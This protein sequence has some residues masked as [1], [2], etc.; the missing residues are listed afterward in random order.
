MEPFLGEIRLFP[1]NFAPKGW[2]YCDGSRLAISANTALFSLLGTTYGGNGV[3]NFA[4][5]DLRGRVAVSQ[6]QGPGL[7]NYSLGE[8]DGV[9]TVTVIGQQIPPHN[10]T[11]N[12]S[13]QASDGS[14]GPT[15]HFLNADDSYNNTADVQMNAGMVTGGPPGAPHENR[16]PLLALAY[17]IATEGIYPSRN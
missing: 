14:R 11:V 5:P 4:V 3:S 15:G 1:Y 16:Q 10:H 7:T 2:M 9:E 17:C 13:S 8:Q 12:A 6:G